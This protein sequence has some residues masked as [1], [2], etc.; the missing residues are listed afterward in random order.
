M[1]LQIDQTI[2]ELTIFKQGFSDCND[3]NNGHESCA[4]INRL[5]IALDI[6]N[7]NDHKETLIQ[8]INVVFGKTNLLND[9]IHLTKKESTPN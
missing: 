6:T 8:F 7:N 3:G 5:I 4:A 9:Y 1:M 2:R